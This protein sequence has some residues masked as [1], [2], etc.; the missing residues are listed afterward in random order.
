MPYYSEEQWLGW[1]D[2][3]AADDYI[4]TDRFL[5]ESIFR[6]TRNFF[7]RQLDREQFS[8]AGIGSGGAHQVE[9]S[10][11][12]DLIYWLDPERDSELADFFILVD[13]MVPYLN[14]YCFLGISDY[15]FHLAKYPPGTGYEKHVDRFKGRNNR[16]ISVV[17][18]LN[19]GWQEGDGGELVIDTGRGSR[20]VEPYGRR[21]VIF[22]SDTVPHAVRPTRVPRYSLTG[23]LLKQPSGL[24]LLIH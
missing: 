12:G 20:V 23:W 19:E 6:S 18:Y 9:K 7:T 21:A 4:V 13:E 1:I 14:R 5:P 17:V 8:R 3:L 15:E 22:R 2:Q 16:L 11:R 24:E 10:V